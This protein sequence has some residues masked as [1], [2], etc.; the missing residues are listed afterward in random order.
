METSLLCSMDAL[1][2][3]STA[4]RIQSLNVPKEQGVRA[5]CLQYLTDLNRYWITSRVQLI[6]PWQQRYPQAELDAIQQIQ[7]IHQTIFQE[8]SPFFNIDQ[9]NHAPIF[10]EKAIDTALSF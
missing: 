3:S 2:T 4:Y 9:S 8:A 10:S 7:D 5:T 1:G 6:W